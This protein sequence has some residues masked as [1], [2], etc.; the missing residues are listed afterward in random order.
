L[1]VTTAAS[2][3]PYTGNFGLGY[4]GEHPVNTTFLVWGAQFST[5][6]TLLDYCK[7]LGSASTTGSGYISKWY[8]QSGNAHDLA[9]AT[10]GLQVRVVSSGLV[11]ANA[12]TRNDDL[13]D[14]PTPTTTTD[15]LIAAERNAKFGALATVS[16]GTTTATPSR[17]IEAISTGLPSASLPPR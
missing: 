11:D 3:S 9:L 13:L 2:G 15:S 14:I 10:T 4:W 7:T 8:D 12:F 1:T 17:Y 5:G 16:A 6:S